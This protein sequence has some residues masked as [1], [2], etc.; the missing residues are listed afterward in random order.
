VHVT[1]LSKLPCH[2]KYTGLPLQLIDEGFSD[3]LITFDQI[4]ELYAD[5]LIL[6]LSWR[7]RSSTNTLLWGFGD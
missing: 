1:V 5:K 4:C 2:S 3:Y 6:D 7:M